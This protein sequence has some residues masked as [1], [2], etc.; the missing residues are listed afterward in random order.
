MIALGDLQDSAAT[1]IL[2]DALQD[3]DE[4]VR[5]YATRALGARGDRSAI[6]ALQSI[7]G[8]ESRRCDVKFVTRSATLKH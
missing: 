8:D 6:L 5:L 2:V 4:W 1:A 7:A 3:E